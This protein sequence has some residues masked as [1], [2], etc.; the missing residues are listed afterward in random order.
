MDPSVSSLN[1]FFDIVESPVTAQT[2]FE[3]P[4]VRHLHD[5]WHGARGSDI[6]RQHDF[7]IVDHR[8]IIEHIFVIDCLPTGDF[9]FRLAGEEVFR[10]IG[11][12]NSGELVKQGAIG[13][14]GTA[15]FEYYTSIVAERRCKHCIGSLKFAGREFR[16][17][18]GI[19]CPLTEDGRVVSR[20]IGVMDL[21][22]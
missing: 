14:Y 8:E 9:I 12:N 20:I 22:D 2:R 1:E 21:I 13:E 10:L 18:E 17:F 11:R 7:D 3:S 4:R 19:D 15:L 5:W 16:R 6:P